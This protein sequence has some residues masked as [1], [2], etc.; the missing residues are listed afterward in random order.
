MQTRVTARPKR[1]PNHADFESFFRHEY[2]RL[3]GALYL[4]TGD[5]GEAEE[6]GQE[7]MARAYERW[8]RI[9]RME[10]PGGYVYG[11]ALNLNR[12]RLRRIGLRAR[13]RLRPEPADDV[14]ARAE[15]RS[16]LIRAMAALPLGQRAALVLVEWIGLSSEEAGRVLGIEAGA[17]RSRT[18]RARAVLKERLEVEDE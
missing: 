6:L 11:I 12:H 18:S 15:A 16:D 8:G 7:A 9:S 17:V 2:L 3:V 4:V 5:S 1:R 14:A 10:S 13:A